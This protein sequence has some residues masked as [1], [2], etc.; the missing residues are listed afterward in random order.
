MY[1][2]GIQHLPEFTSHRVEDDAVLTFAH[3]YKK[4]HQSK[5]RRGGITLKNYY[6]LI[7]SGFL[8][9]NIMRMR[10]LNGNHAHA[11]SPR[12]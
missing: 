10:N 8:G 6:L 9:P 7:F 2:G 3:A 11:I 12:I 5:G 1:G 4:V